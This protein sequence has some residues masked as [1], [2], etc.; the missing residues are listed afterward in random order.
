MSKFV[1]PSAWLRQ[2]FTASRTE[3]V[4]PSTVSNDV[5]LVQPFD[6]SGWGLPDAGSWFLSVVSAAGAKVETELLV[7]PANTIV[8]LLAIS[9]S[10]GAGAAFNAQAQVKPQGGSPTPF[11]SFVAVPNTGDRRAL[12]VYC[13]ILGPGSILQGAHEGGD[14]S[15]TCGFNVYY[16][17][18]PIGTVFYV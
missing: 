3:H 6:G 7:V 12:Q 14:A 4:A 13:P 11:T 8:R 9:A 1:R 2:L 10:R 5:S 17:Q 15:S 18:A 16:C